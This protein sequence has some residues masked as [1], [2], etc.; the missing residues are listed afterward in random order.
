M[1]KYHL[2]KKRYRIQLKGLTLEF[3]EQLKI[4]KKIERLLEKIP[5]DSKIILKITKKEYLE[6][7][8][9]VQSTTFGCSLK[10]MAENLDELVRKLFYC[11]DDEVNDW[12]HSPSY[13]DEF[14]SYF[15]GYPSYYR[16]MTV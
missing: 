13:Q 5:S 3:N 12:K 15:G 1:N 10:T 14:S 8:I 2:N 16:E 9:Q 6:A 4:Y 11:I 7:S